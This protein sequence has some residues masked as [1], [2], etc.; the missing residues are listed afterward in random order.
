MNANAKID[1]SADL[2]AD[3]SSTGDDMEQYLPAEC[4]A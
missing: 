1:V 3:E 2:G 4:F